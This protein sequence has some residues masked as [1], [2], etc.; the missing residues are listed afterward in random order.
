MVRVAL[1]TTGDTVRGRGA[2]V[3][4]ARLVLVLQGHESMDGRTGGRVDRWMDGRVDGWPD[5]QVDVW[6]GGRVD[7]RTSER[8]DGWTGGRM[9]GRMGGQVDGR[10]GGQVDGRR[11][12]RTDGWTDEQTD[13]SRTSPWGTTKDL[14]RVFPQKVMTLGSDLPH[15]GFKI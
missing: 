8:T 15:P 11:D 14:P 13:I 6:T 9:D 5:E 1:L 7:G 12:G 10:T 3:R 2:V 4:V